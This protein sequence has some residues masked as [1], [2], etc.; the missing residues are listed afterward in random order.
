MFA[1]IL[2]NGGGHA[3]NLMMRMRMN[4]RKGL[5]QLLQIEFEETK[6]CKPFRLEAHG[7]IRMLHQSNSR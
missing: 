1:L 2:I 4:V 6:K 7:T 3:C 5:P